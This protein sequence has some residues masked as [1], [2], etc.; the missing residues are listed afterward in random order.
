MDDTSIVTQNFE[1]TCIEC[2]NQ[3][4]TEQGKNENDVIEC[5]FCGIEYEIIEVTTDGQYILELLE[6]EK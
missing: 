3:N 2:Q 6:E 5:G 1:F 4:T